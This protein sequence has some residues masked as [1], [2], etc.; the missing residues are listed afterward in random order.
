MNEHRGEKLLAAVNQSRYPKTEIAKKLQ[1]GRATLYNYFERKD[2]E[3]DVIINIYNLLKKE[4]TDDFPELKK[5][6]EAPQQLNEND[7]LK[8]CQEELEEIRLKYYKLL[9]KHNNLLEKVA[10]GNLLKGE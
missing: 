7:A 6:V 8:S 10:T 9:E 5:F 4:V 3:Y 2:L 1:I